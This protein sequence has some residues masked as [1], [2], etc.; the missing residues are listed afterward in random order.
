MIML[1]CPVVQSSFNTQ[2]S[3]VIVMYLSESRVQS[4][5]FQRGPSSLAVYPETLSTPALSS[6]LEVRHPFLGDQLDGETQRYD[7][8][9][10]RTLPSNK[11]TFM[12]ASQQQQQQQAG[13]GCTLDPA[14]IRPGTT[15]RHSSWLKG[16]VGRRC[17]S[18]G[19]RSGEGWGV[20]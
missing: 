17:D 10:S 3:T 16:L 19:W 20:P 5:I 9:F 15:Q 4:G 7:S 14:W 12:L 2:F 11:N 13:G 1:V 8:C 6:S 18:E